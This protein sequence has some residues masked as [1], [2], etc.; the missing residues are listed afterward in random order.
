M[1]QQSTSHIIMVRPDHFGFNS[2]TAKTNPFQHI[3]T[4]VHKSAAEIRHAAIGEFTK[5]VEELK[6]HGI[7]VSLL[8]SRLDVTT[9]DAVFPN[10]WFS[11]HHDGKLIIYPILTQNRRS[12]RQIE[13]LLTL[14]QQMGVANYEVIDLT[15]DEENGLFLEST[16]SMIFDRVHKVA[17]AMASPR[18]IKKEFEKWCSLMGYEGVF[19]QSTE[20]H[21]KAV[22]H[23]NI[24]MSIGS[25][26]AI[27]CFEVI[28]DKAEREKVL[29]KLEGLGKEVISISFEQVYQFCGNILELSTKSGEK[30]IIMSETA[31]KAF[32]QEQR[33][34]LEKY[35]TIV[36]FSIPTIEE[37]GGGGVRCMVAEI[38]R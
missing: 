2:Q 38:F 24:N 30:I 33:H 31:R 36:S 34:H 13:V 7:E 9:P 20:K 23:T 10:N 25:E 14:L 19:I 22:Y 8:P 5:M 16:G 11:S 6:Q 3:P 18:T 12:E 17:F 28:E 29:N 35:G 1:L 37:I 4:T 26:F 15:K 32:T 27:V 21:T